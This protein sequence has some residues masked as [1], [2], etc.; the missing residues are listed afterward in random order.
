MG[1]TTKWNCKSIE[2]CLFFQ[3]HESSVDS[4]YIAQKELTHLQKLYADYYV[5]NDV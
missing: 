2:R 4:W 1:T 5:E 3:A